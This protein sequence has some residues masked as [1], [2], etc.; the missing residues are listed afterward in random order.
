MMMFTMPEGR[1][2]HTLNVLSDGAIILCGGSTEK[3]ALAPSNTCLQFKVSI[4]RQIVINLITF[5]A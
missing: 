2:G 4:I 5:L 3:Y 1:Q